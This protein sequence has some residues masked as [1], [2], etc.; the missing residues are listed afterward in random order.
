M[1]SRVGEP[2]LVDRLHDRRGRRRR[3]REVKQ[4]PRRAAERLLRGREGLGVVAR[5]VGARERQHRG[6]PLPRLVFDGDPRMLVQRVPDQLLE[7]VVVELVERQPD[8]PALLRQQPGHHQVKAPGDDHP[9][10]EVAGPADESDHR[11]VRRLHRTNCRSSP[12][13]RA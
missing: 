13:M 2:R 1:R 6:E 3:D 7:P 11:C 10:R 8:D 12:M 5:V 9:S 4:S